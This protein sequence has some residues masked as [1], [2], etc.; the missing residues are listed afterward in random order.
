MF[1]VNDY[2]V[3]GLKGVCKIGSIGKD[4]YK[5]NEETDYYFLSPVYNND[6]TIMVP[7][8]NPNIVMR[9][10]STKDDVLSLIATMSEIEPVWIDNERQRDANFKA[11]LKTG[12]PEEWVKIIKTIYLEKETRSSVGKKLTRTDEETFHTAEENLHQELAIVLNISPGEVVPYILEHIS[13]K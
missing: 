1:K 8:N 4:G 2:V 6:M 12:K 13:E 11:A 10:I 5:N 7:V 9:H 3:Y